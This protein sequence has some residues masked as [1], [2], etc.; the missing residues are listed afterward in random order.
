MRVT[1]FEADRDVGGRGGNFSML[2]EITKFLKQQTMSR[3]GVK[4][5]IVGGA[6]NMFHTC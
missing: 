2:V 4:I 3:G 6:G 1:A 5:R